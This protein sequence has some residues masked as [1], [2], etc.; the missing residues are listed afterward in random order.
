M[1]ANKD[2]V[3]R[4][5]SREAKSQDFLAQ[6]SRVF[7][8]VE[9]NTVFYALPSAETVTRWGEETPA[10]FRFCMKIPQAISHEKMLQGTQEELQTFLERFAPIEDRLGAHFLLLPKSFQPTHLGL[11][12]AFLQQMPQG[13]SCA[14]EVRDPVFFAG[15]AERRLNEL[16]HRYGADRVILDSRG[17]Y[18]AFAENPNLKTTRRRKP[19]LPVKAY[20]TAKQPFVRLICHPRWEENLDLMAYWADV[21]IHWLKQDLRPYL[22]FH[23]PEDIEAP[24]HAQAFHALLRERDP[25]IPPLPPFPASLQD[26]LPSQLTLF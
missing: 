12:E 5:F 4:L 25:S 10:G 11:L 18:R 3:G 7:S 20:V 6:Y 23:T 15:A 21:V 19:L 26:E 16:L 14:V 2:W 22:F 1:W 17:V 8:T 13:A 24:A 9:G